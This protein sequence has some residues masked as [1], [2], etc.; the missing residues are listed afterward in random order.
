MIGVLQCFYFFAPLLKDKLEFGETSE[1][2]SFELSTL[3]DIQKL[4]KMIQ[5]TSKNWMQKIRTQKK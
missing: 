1:A 5:K 4:G 3:K 2:K